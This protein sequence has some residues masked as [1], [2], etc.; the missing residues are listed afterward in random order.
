MSLTSPDRIELNPVQRQRLR[1]LI[2]AGTTAQQLAV[3]ARIVL[4]AAAQWTN[5][6]I[7]QRLGVCVWTPFASGVIRGA[8]S[9]VPLR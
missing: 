2:R 8:S 3:R 5:T 6:R 7:A 4:L 9:R 1:H